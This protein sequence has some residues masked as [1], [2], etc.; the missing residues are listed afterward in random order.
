MKI[1]N[2]KFI[3]PV[4]PKQ[5]IRGKISVVFG[6]SDKY[7]KITG[8]PLIKGGQLEDALTGAFFVYTARYP[9]VIQP[10]SQPQR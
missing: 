10:E 9:A 6:R 4:L 5:Q 3:I 8:P 2:V 7:N 1:N